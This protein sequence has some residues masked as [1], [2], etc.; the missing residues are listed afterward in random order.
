MSS[1]PEQPAESTGWLG[2][3]N[4]I[5]DFDLLPIRVETFFNDQL[6]AESNRAHVMFELGHAPVYYFPPEALVAECFHKSDRQTHCPYKGIASYWHLK[7][8]DRMVEN[9]VWSY[10]EPYA[11]VVKIKGFRGFYWGRMDRWTEDGV[12]IEGPREIPGRVNTTNQLKATFPQ[13]AREWHPTRNMGISP[14]EFTADSDTEVWWKDASG[15]EWKERIRD[16]AL[17][18]TRHRSDGDATPY[19]DFNPY[20]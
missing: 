4:Y 2:N 14:Y 20:P 9:V 3:P 13:L 8:G 18:L 19:G 6:V 10:E 5:V 1:V 15:R 11:Q 17:A 7:V 12:T 16:R